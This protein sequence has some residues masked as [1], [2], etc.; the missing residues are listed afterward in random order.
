MLNYALFITKLPLDGWEKL[1]SEDAL[2]S[3][4]F[5]IFNKSENKRVSYVFYT[6]RTC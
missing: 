2:Y 4:L 6:N 1:L 5:C 3:W